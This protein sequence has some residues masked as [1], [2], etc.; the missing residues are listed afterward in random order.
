MKSYTIYLIRHS[1]SDFPQP[2]IPQIMGSTDIELSAQGRAL[3]EQAGEAISEHPVNAVFCSKLKRARQTAKLM[4]PDSTP[5]VIDGLEEYSFGELEGKS[6]EE[7]LGKEYNWEDFFSAVG[8]C[9]EA[10]PHQAFLDRICGAFAKIIEG[11]MKSGTDSAAIISH[12]FTIMHLM[13]TF[14]YP[15]MDKVYDWACGNCCGFVLRTDATLWM[16]DRALETV[17]VIEEGKTEMFERL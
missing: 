15:K 8:K 10:E 4:Y 7:L 5:L 12:G 13:A 1:I 9:K 3:A 11:C 14:T 2:Q 6:F 16:R 17:G